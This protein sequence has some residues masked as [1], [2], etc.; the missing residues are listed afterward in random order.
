MCE[1]YDAQVPKQCTEDD[2]E[3]VTEKER[4]NFCD[5]FKPGY[6]RF[7]ARAAAE[8]S[9]ATDALAALFGEEKVDAAEE[10]PLVQDAEDLFK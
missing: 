2:A 9:R 3:E 4:L 8:E 5:W 10:D 6:G 7:D 1:F